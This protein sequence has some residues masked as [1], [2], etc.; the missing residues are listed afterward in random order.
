MQTDVTELKKVMVDR[1]INTVIEL[2]ELCGVNRNTLGKILNGKE[3]PSADTM[4]RLVKGL[5]ISPEKAGSIF[6]NSNLRT[7]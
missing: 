7:T 1:N 2:S 4:Y 3:Q 6:F 5:C